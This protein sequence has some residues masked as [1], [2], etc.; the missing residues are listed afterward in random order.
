MIRTSKVEYFLRGHFLYAMQ[1][2][3]NLV[4]AFLNKV[5]AF[6]YSASQSGKLISNDFMLS[7]R[8]I[9]R[10]L[11]TALTAS[12]TVSDVFWSIRILKYLPCRTIKMNRN[13]RFQFL[14]IL[15]HP[16]PGNVRKETFAPSVQN[17]EN[18]YFT[19]RPRI[20]RGFFCIYL[21]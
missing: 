11:R 17:N 18:S 7:K 5:F 1:H 10:L 6:I 15:K 9:S 13:V 16:L 21:S 8:M 19:K 20:I 14:R 3:G 12:N 2:R 4:D